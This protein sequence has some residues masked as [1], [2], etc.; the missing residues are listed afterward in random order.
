LLEHFVAEFTEVVHSFC[1]EVFLISLL[2]NVGDVLIGLECRRNVL[3]QLGVLE[4]VSLHTLFEHNV[5]EFFM[6]VLFAVNSFDLGCLV[7]TCVFVDF[8]VQNFEDFFKS[9][10]LLI[11]GHVH[12]LLLELLG[13]QFNNGHND[14]EVVFLLCLRSL[15]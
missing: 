10:V 11:E 1:F 2:Q 12:C 9:G 7:L 8:I 13:F 6:Q 4:A 5:N 15:L 3:D 14:S